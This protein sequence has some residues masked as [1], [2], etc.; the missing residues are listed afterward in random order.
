MKDYYTV[1]GISRNASQ[2]DIKKAYRRL[3]HQYHPDKTGGNEEKF[4]EVNEAYQVLGNEQKRAQYDR[5]GSS[6]F[7]GGTGNGQGF[8]WDF[9]NFAQGFEGVDLGDVFGD[10]F[11]FGTQGS[12]RQTLR[13]RDIAIDIELSFAESVFGVDRNVL[14]R[15]MVMCATCKATGR[16]S[17][18]SSKPCTNCN[19]SGSIH[20]TRRSF[21]GSF[22]KLRACATCHGTGKVPETPCHACRGEG[23][24]QASEE[25]AVSIPPGINDGEMIKL[26]G[27]GEAIT[28]GF[29][30]DLYVKIHVLGHKNFIRTGF[31]I[32]TSLSVSVT[33]ALLGTEKK[34]ETLEGVIWIQIPAGTESGS[35]LRI[36]GKGIPRARGGRGDLLI[37]VLVKPPRKLSK[38]ARQLLEELKKEGI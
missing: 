27:K 25:I 2:E 29:P 5:F 23:I 19:G 16:E 30:G 3:A 33:D 6:G 38:K 22:T 15:K 28:G 1:L 11:G 13:G 31:D 32:A 34:M 26:V 18:T 8:E 7:S 9:S 24:L 10:I 21:F 20:E 35:I 17:G 14:L 4:K 12:G 36:R 37:K